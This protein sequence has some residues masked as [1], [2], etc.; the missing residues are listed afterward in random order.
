MCVRIERYGRLVALIVALSIAAG[1]G[2]RAVAAPLCGGDCDGDGAVTIDE[3]LL[4]VSI[5][6]G[7]DDI[8]RCPAMDV[9]DSDQ[10]KVTGLVA[11][12][13]NSLDGCPTVTCTAPQGG[14]CVEVA[15]GDQ[16]GLLNALIN[17]EPNDIIS[18]AAGRYDIT[19]QLSLFHVDNV[20]IA[21][22]GMNRTVLSFAHEAAG[23]E[24]LQIE[25]NGCTVQDIGLEDGPGDLLKVIGADGVTIRRVRAEWT[26]GPATTN[27]SYGF[28][29]SLSRNILIADSMAMGA[30]DTGIYVGQSRDIIVRRNRAALNVSGIEIENS[31]DADVVDNIVTENTGGV[32]VFDTPGPPAQGGRRTRVFNNQIFANNTTNFAPS[33]NTVA[34]VPTGTGTMVLANDQV[35]IFGNTFRDN[36]T[37]HLLLIGYNIAVMAGEPQSTNPAYDPYSETLFVHDNTFV[38][39]GMNPDPSLRKL[40]IVTI[41]G[42]LPLPD[43]LYDGDFN[44][45]EAVN[46]E[47]PDN[48][49]TCVQEPKAT[50]L[51]LDLGHSPPNVNHDLSKLDCTQ[52]PLPPQVVGMGPHVVITPGPGAEEQL[53]T[54]LNT[55]PFAPGT[56]I[57]L[58]AGTYELTQQIAIN[59]DHVTLRGEGM[60]KTILRFDHATANVPESVLVQGNDFVLK[61][62]AIEDSHGDQ[63]KII[64]ADGV[65]VQRVRTEWTDGA[66][67][68][69]GAYGIYPVQCRDVLVEDC[70]AKGASDT[71]IYV[72]QSRNI[73]IR[74]NDAELNVAGIEIE[75]STAADVHDNT[76]TRN[77]GGILVFNLPGLQVFGQQTRVYDNM[78]F[79]NNTLNFAP[80][81]NIVAGVPTGT[82]FMIL[83]NDHVEAFGN[84]FSDN[85]TAQ[86]ILVSYNSAEVLGGLSKPNDPNFDPY[87]ESLYIHDNTYTGGGTMPPKNATFQVLETLLGGLPIPQI[88]YDGDVDPAK[89]QNGTLPDALRTCI[90]ESAATFVDLDVAHNCA[91]LSHVSTVVN[92][93][94]DPLPAV[95]IAGVN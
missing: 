39:G 4:G 77:A 90:Q 61:D 23:G 56:D 63:F 45:A 69:N 70:V 64:G 65:R 93:A 25:A 59:A 88:V 38:R 58:P 92:C 82:G 30:S 37:T 5:M 10:V 78:S 85:D 75:N 73:I 55:S 3:L 57:L 41:N 22:Q 47:L 11:A 32:L 60:D 18:L 21:G 1:S 29:P 28:Y 84:A 62:L 87:S 44:P 19:Q 94:L 50:L 14:R 67:P 33:G 89:L 9:D 79:A 66:Q 46:G 72:G 6:L 36:D 49:R 80:P 26:N 51:N 20:T 71:G 86:V 13:K 48:L 95:A 54:V 83:A 42:G 76:A 15:A 12:V 68:G 16:D 74:N 35:E 24:G 8:A 81:G 40:G 27:G 34:V 52:P 31:V 17:A 2:R 53:Q 91:A 43:I 7:R